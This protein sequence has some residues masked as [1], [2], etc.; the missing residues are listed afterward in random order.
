[1]YIFRNGPTPGNKKFLPLFPKVSWTVRSIQGP[2]P[3]P[4]HACLYG[5]I[6]Y[7]IICSWHPTRSHGPPLWRV[8]FGGCILYIFWW[9]VRRSRLLALRFKR[10][11][12]QRS[13]LF[14]RMWFIWGG[15][16]DGSIKSHEDSHFDFLV[17][18]EFSK[19]VLLL[20]SLF[21]DTGSSRLFN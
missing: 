9:W 15:I 6:Y 1:M 11:M 17:N 12:A 5:I 19:L 7:L 20:A 13:C 4:I 3:F 14:V 18:T 2:F 21:G 16:L 10:F 8:L